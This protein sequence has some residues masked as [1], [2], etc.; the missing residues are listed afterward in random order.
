VDGGRD[1]D[2]MHDLLMCNFVFS[3]INGIHDPVCNALSVWRSVTSVQCEQFQTS[4]IA[5]MCGKFLLGMLK[6]EQFAG[7]AAI[8]C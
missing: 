5:Y 8:L 3:G 7:L 1:W 2:I 6:C 4:D